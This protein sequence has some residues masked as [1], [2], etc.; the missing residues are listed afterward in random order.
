[1]GKKKQYLSGMNTTE[2]F[3]IALGL[4]RPWYI[5]QIELLPVEESKAKELHIH[6]DFEKG[7]KF[8]TVSNMCSSA[9]DTEEKTWQHLNFFQHRCYLHA[10]VPRVKDEVCGKVTQIQVPWAR[11]GSGFT[12]LF[13][14]YAMLLIESEM[15]VCKAAENLSIT[16]PRLWR[17]FDYWIERAVV[18]D[19]LSETKRIGID[20]T[21]RKKGHEYITQVVD[22]DARRTI[23]VTEGKG[24]KTV[25]R[26]V[27]KLEEKGGKAENIELTSQAWICLPC[28]LPLR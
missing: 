3:N 8:I 13:E 17:V 23:F 12:L 11:E 18:S 1:V 7:F 21:S 4:S 22:L 19:G 27:E 24:K 26:F 10:R 20:E 15:P 9:Y 25:E 28:L 16:A 14:A 2:L 5:R 6:L